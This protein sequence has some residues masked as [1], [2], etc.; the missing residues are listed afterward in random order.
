MNITTTVEMNITTTVAMNILYTNL[1]GP[2][3]HPYF[4]KPALLCITCL[5]E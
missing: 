4:L 3:S 5:W 1:A 2:T